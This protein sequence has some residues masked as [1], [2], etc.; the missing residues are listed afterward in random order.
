M[1]PL[2]PLACPLCSSRLWQTRTRGVCDYISAERFDLD[3]CASCGL[4][5]TRPMPGDDVIERYYSARYRGDRHAFTDRLRIA[6]RARMLARHLPGGGSTGRVLDVGCGWGDFAHHLRDRGWQVSVTEINAASLEKLRALGI[7]AKTPDEAMRDG[8]GHA[9]E[10]VTCWHVL[11]HVLRPGELVRW[12]HGLLAPGG[13]FQVTVPTL[14]S[15]QARMFGANWLHLDVPRHRYHFDE[16]TLRRILT[17]NGFDVIGRS[18][19]AFEYDWMGFIQSALN[20]VCSR[21]NVLFERVTSQSRAWPRSGADGSMRLRDRIDVVS[22][23]LLGPPVAAATL[24][25]CLLSWFCGRGA[26]LTLT[27]RLSQPK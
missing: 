1:D 17:D 24:P 14:S 20:A 3:A 23:C 5:V 26:T 4:V 9:F 16:R 10:A 15:W 21:P 22:T 25:I 18:T 12:V 7:E 19:F 8:F 2:E 6:L 27:C 11:E 13:I